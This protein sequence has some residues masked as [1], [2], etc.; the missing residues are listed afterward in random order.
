MLFDCPSSL[1]SALDARC[2]KVLE[3]SHVGEG[4]GRSCPDV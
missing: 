1:A 3:V 2:E 4:P